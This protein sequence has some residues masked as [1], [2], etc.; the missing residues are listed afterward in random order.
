[1]GLHQRLLDN[2]LP[3]L[4]AFAVLRLELALI[5]II[6]PFADGFTVHCS[7]YAVIKLRC[8]SPMNHVFP[9]EISDL[10]FQG[11]DPLTCGPKALLHVHQITSVSRFNR[12]RSLRIANRL[13]FALQD[14]NRLK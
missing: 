10:R 13:W 1:V 8:V 7:F 11:L 6:A 5:V 3:F 4:A 12:L 14:L 2:V 9:E